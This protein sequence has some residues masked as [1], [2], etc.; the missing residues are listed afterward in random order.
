[1]KVWNK[2]YSFLTRIIIFFSI[3]T[4]SG[5]FIFPLFA[6]TSMPSIDNY[7]YVIGLGLD[8][9]ESEALK[10]TFQVAIPT[11]PSSSGENSSN[12][13]DSSINTVDCSSIDSGIN[14]LNDYLSKE[15]SLTHCKVLVFSEE[16]A[17]QGIYNYI[18]TLFNDV[19]LRPTCAIFVSRSSA[20]SFLESSGTVFQGVTSESYELATRSI[21]YNGYISNINVGEFFSSLHDTFSQG[22]ATLVSVNN[23]NTVSINSSISPSINSIGANPDSNYYAGESPINRDQ[24]SAEHLGLAVFKQ[25]KLVGELNG[26]ET[27]SHLIITNKLNEATVTIPNPFDEKSFID[28]QIERKK[29]TKSKVEIINGTPFITSD[30]TLEAKLLSID[31]ARD[32]S[33]EKDIEKISNYASTYFEQNILE[34]LYKTSKFYQ[35]DIASFG[36]KATS[37]FLFWNDWEEYDWLSHYQDSFFKVNVSTHIHSSSFLQR[38]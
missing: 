36:S 7:A 21:Q 6:F 24:N 19:E 3:L 34:Y 1:M 17:S 18:N 16:L 26:I 28:L 13:Q 20:A 11:S 5:F 30:V 38:V 9:G 37:K 15:V 12:S 25:D 14:I 31:S 22:Y 23:Q 29:S 10:I 32:Y 8:K 4:I 33:N 35:S 2:L 27:L